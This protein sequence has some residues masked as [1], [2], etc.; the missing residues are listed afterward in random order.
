MYIH[1]ALHTI[2]ITFF[3]P[4]AFGNYNH[5]LPTTTTALFLQLFFSPFLSQSFL[6]KHSVHTQKTQYMYT[7]YTY[8]KSKSHKTNI[9]LEFIILLHVIIYYYFMFIF[10]ITLFFFFILLSTSIF[11]ILLAI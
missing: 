11:I 5:S 8:N 4:C 1:I 3:L 2:I 9:L 10:F 6:S 7:T